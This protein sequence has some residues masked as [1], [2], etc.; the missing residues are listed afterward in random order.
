MHLHEK[1]IFYKLQ[2]N[3]YF[4][5]LFPCIT[6]GSQ[7]STKRL[8]S[9]FRET[10]QRAE[11]QAKTICLTGYQLKHHRQHDLAPVWGF[12]FKWPQGELHKAN[13]GSVWF[14]NMCHFS[15]N[16]FDLLALWISISPRGLQGVAAFI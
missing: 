7:G 5:C 2:I 11:T 9:K 4:E 14:Y 12:C 1:N 3:I 8:V 6:S 13:S 10:F 16:S 15:M